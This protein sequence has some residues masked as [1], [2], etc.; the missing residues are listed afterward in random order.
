MVSSAI[1]ML[2]GR[3]VAAITSSRL[4]RWYSESKRSRGPDGS[5][6]SGM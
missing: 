3:W 5:D 2:I 4:V 1:S 6:G